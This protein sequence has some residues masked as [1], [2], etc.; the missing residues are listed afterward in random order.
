MAIAAAVVVGLI[1]VLWI[2]SSGVLRPSSS[3]PLVKEGESPPPLRHQ[4]PLQRR[5]L[6]PGERKERTDFFARPSVGPPLVGNLL[7]LGNPG[8]LEF[9]KRNYAAKGPVFSAKILHKTLTFIIGPKESAPFFQNL[10]DVFSQNEVYGF[11]THVFGKDVV[12]DAAPPKRRAQ[13]QNMSKG[14]RADRLKSYVP[15]IVGRRRPS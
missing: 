11:M 8:P 2:V 14:L 6:P 4:S 3:P 7:G 13:M 9:I 15:K 5:R 10:D 12:Y 1:G